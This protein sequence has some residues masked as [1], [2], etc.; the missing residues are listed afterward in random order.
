MTPLIQEEWHLPM[1][2]FMIIPSSNH[3]LRMVPWGKRSVCPVGYV[4]SEGRTTWNRY[5]F[6]GEKSTYV[7]GRSRFHIAWIASQIAQ[8][9][10]A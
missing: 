2:P 10:P 4:R 8:M 7:L 5:D 6:P 9:P 3:S 1:G